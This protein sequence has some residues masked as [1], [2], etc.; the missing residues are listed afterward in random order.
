MDKREY[1]ELYMWAFGGVKDV[2]YIRLHVYL[3]IFLRILSAAFQRL[4]MLCIS[5]S[6][7]IYD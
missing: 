1:S 4:A 2:Q 3:M 5:L 6:G 7:L